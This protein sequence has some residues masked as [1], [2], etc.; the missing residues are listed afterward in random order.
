MTF[1][2][3]ANILDFSAQEIYSMLLDFGCYPV[4]YAAVDLDSLAIEAKDRGFN[5]LG[6]MQD[7]FLASEYFKV[8][9]CFTTWFDADWW[10]YPPTQL[11]NHSSTKTPEY[12]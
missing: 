1:P 7:L 4:N 5:T 8:L 9:T 3:T 11:K 2:I 6:L 12:P 10:R